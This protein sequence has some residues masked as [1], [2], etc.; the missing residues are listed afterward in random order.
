MKKQK[1][2]VSAGIDKLNDAI[3]LKT[4]HAGDMLTQHI[5][6]LQEKAVRQSLIDLGW[7]PP[8][9]D[10]KKIIKELLD[11]IWEERH[12]YSSSEE[13][14]KQEFAEAVALT[15]WKSRHEK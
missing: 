13:A 15:G 11:E 4:K 2:E 5:I 6:S 3:L 14:F 1:I 12:T 7:T 10:H 9:T 8:E